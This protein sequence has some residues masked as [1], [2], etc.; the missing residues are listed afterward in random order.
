M[1]KQSFKVV[2]PAR[3]E[4]ARFPGKILAK[5]ND[6]PMIQHVYER[7]AESDAD[8]IVIAVDDKYVANEVS[9][10]M[11]NVELTCSGQ[12]TGTDRIR[13]VLENRGWSDDT[14][15]V[16]V[17][18]DSPLISPVSI[19]QVGR[20]LTTFS[21]ADVAT[22]ATRITKTEDFHDSNIV[23]V[24][25]DARGYALYFSRAPIPAQEGYNVYAWRHLG[26]YGYTVNAVRMI[27]SSPPVPIER[28]EKLE[29][30]RAMYMGLK[31]K[32]AIAEEPHDID[33]DV[34]ADVKTVENI[35]I[36]IASDR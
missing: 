10:F 16:N 12:P 29:Q 4:S 8:E 27:T 30:L 18:G 2:I 21:E 5:I 6:K 36:D 34:P 23:K 22:L 17:Q 28:F 13:E 9:R 26:I 32:V 35:M 3:L 20:L 11:D 7:V 33:V 15:I 14:K 19:N 1:K 24:V 31:I 25:W